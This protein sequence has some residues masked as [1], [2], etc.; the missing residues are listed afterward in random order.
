[1]WHTVLEGWGDC[2][3][4]G[5]LGKSYQDLHLPVILQL[6]FRACA[7]TSVSLRSL[8]ASQPNKMH[9]EAAIPWSSLA[10]L[11]V[12][13]K[14]LTA[15]SLGEGKSP[16]FMVSANFC[17]IN[18]PTIANFKLP[19]ECHRVSNHKESSCELVVSWLRCTTDLTTST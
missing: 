2:Q 14:C 15:G 1:M 18:Y 17:S 16:G 10:K 7:C 5:L 3:S 6:L 4:Q 9:A 8:Q 11:L 12:A 19:T 13:G